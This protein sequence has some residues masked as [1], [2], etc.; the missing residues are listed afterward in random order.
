MAIKKPKVRI[1]VT[2][3]V[4]QGNRRRTTTKTYTK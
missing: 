1:K 4:K 3:T 2:T